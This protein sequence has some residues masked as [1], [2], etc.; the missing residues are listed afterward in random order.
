MRQAACFVKKG[1]AIIILQHRG[2]YTNAIADTGNMHEI[3]DQE[4]ARVL[5]IIIL[6]LDYNFHFDA[7]LLGTCLCCIKRFQYSE[8]VSNAS[9]R[10]QCRAVLLGAERPLQAAPQLQRPQNRRIVLTGAH[11][12]HN[13]HRGGQMVHLQ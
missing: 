1:Q 10:L 3:Q 5:D 7:P 8:A 13:L 2:G 4:Q 11:L 12:S 6:S 9:S